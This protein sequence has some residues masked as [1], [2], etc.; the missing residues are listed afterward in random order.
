MQV[1]LV[2][3]KLRKTQN[4]PRPL[5]PLLSVRSGVEETIAIKHLSFRVQRFSRCSFAGVDAVFGFL[6]FYNSMSIMRCNSGHVS[7]LPPKKHKKHEITDWLNFLCSLSVLLPATLHVVLDD[8]LI[9]TVVLTWFRCVC[10][11][12]VTLLLTCYCFA[13]KSWLRGEFLEGYR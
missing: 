11:S 9:V 12:V 7:L 3:C 8:I 10:F 1:C 2:H 5:L 13:C 4:L 6:L